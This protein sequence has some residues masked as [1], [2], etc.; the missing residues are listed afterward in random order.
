[1][2]FGSTLEKSCQVAAQLQ[3]DVKQPKVPWQSRDTLL[4]SAEPATAIVWPS[5]Q[6]TLARDSSAYIAGKVPQEM[7][8]SFLHALSGGETIIL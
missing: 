7:Q 4:S 2:G 6:T 1:M 3:H 5:S 8:Q